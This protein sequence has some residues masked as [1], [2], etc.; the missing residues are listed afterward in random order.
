MEKILFCTANFKTGRGGISSY[1]FDF[2][3]AFKDMYEIV[4]IASGETEKSNIKVYS[5][6]YLDFTKKM[7]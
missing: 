7:P 5:C 3:E 2:I 4:V 6:N 1:A